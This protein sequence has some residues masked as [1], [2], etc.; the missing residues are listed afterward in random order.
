MS[1]SK[2]SR[3]DRLSTSVRVICRS[4]WQ[5]VREKKKGNPNLFAIRHLR[6]V[7]T[8]IYT[9]AV[10]LAS[11][12]SRFQVLNRGWKRATADKELPIRDRL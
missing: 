4:R 9:P 8:K 3:G 6:Q 11:E 2:H 12:C 10:R 5:R 1:Q 7:H